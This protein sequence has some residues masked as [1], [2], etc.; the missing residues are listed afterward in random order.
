LGEETPDF[1]FAFLLKAGRA[2]MFPVYK[3][4]YERGDG[5]DSDYP[6]QTISYKDHVIM[7]VKDISRSID[8][9][10]TR[11]DI[12]SSKLAYLGVS[13]GGGMGAIVPAVEK[14]LDTSVLFVAGLYFQRALP[15]VDGVNYVSRVTHPV[16]M[17]NGEYDFFFPLETSQRPMFELLGTPEKDKRW[18][19]YPGSHSFPW[20]E[21]IRESLDWLDKYLGPV[22]Q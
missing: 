19:V 20:P 22:P 11:E 18:R 17:L 15:E 7:W 14:R 1:D 21:V 4:T 13:W 16:L 5:L 9:L 2:V 3:G 6:E 10:E 12:D 8:Y